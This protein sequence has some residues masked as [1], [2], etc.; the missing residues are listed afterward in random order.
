M[1]K[2]FLVLAS[3]CLVTTGGCVQ[4]NNYQ[5]IEKSVPT[6]SV[7]GE[8]IVSAIPD[9]AVISFGVTSE[10][11]TLEKAYEDNT[12]KM[13]AVIKAVKGKGV[14]DEDVTTSSYNISPVYPRDEK[15]RIIY[16][17]PS[18]F[19]VSQTIV[20][21]VRKVS[22]TGDVIDSVVASGTNRFSG[23]RFTS[24]K[25]D[26]L[27]ARAKAMAAE[28]SRDKAELI[29]KSLGGQVGRILR[30]DASRIQPYP[31][32]AN[33]MAFEA[34]SVRATPQIEAG[35]LEVNATCNVIYEL[36]Q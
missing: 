15:G 3:L 35:T 28:D 22:I 33:T 4:N 12:R 1:Y 9:E 17:K 8:A 11:K 29:A 18:A 32:R 16:G 34:A 13:N 2:I 5:S 6:I 20:V 31:A 21:K 30:V 27:K 24:S 36:K 14:S 19:K 7:Q 23:I 10:A 26:E 25:M